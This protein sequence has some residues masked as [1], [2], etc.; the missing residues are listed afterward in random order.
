MNRA[1][2]WSAWVSAGTAALVVLSFTGCAHVCPSADVC[3]AQATDT[4]FVEPERALRD[5]S[6]AC[7]MGDGDACLMAAWMNERGHGRQQASMDVALTLYERACAIHTEEMGRPRSSACFHARR[8][9]D[10]N[11]RPKQTGQPY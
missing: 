9:E 3:T 7:D 4:H 10:E 8:L 2:V 11:Q 5:Y 1:R 6:Q